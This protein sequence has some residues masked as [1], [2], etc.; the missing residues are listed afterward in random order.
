ML[1]CS[2]L[3]EQGH[4]I[5]FQLINKVLNMIHN[6]AYVP[7]WGNEVTNAVHYI[8]VQTVFVSV[9]LSDDSD[10]PLGATS[11]QRYTYVDGTCCHKN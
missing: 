7:H 8:I 2:E 10:M 5:I 9:S 3:L 6:R 1:Q 4:S 11:C